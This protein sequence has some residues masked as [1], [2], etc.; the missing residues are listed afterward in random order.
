MNLRTDY[1]RKFKEHLSD[2]GILK[3]YETCRKM[4]TIIEFF[5]K[6]ALV[7]EMKSVL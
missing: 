3:K 7:W 5:L 2:K 4:H 6:Y 1:Q